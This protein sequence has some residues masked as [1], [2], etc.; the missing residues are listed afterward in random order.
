MSS[1]TLSIRMPKD[2]VPWPWLHC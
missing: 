1:Y 2:K